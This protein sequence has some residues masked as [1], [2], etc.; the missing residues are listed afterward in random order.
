MAAR[1]K[2]T[3]DE[4][5][6]LA[7]GPVYMLLHVGGADATI[8]VDEWSALVKAVGEQADHHSELVRELMAEVASDWRS[9]PKEWTDTWHP[10]DG[11]REVA[12]ILDAKAGDDATPV[13]ETLL[14][15]GAVV[16]T[17]SGSKLAAFLQNLAGKGW[18]GASADEREA[19]FTAAEALGRPRFVD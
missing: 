1:A 10:I 15:L 18:G 11:L 19:L 4:W 8:D 9:G 12:A 13:K 3:D 6:T 7:Y 17:A 14:E 2:F 5:D 16:A